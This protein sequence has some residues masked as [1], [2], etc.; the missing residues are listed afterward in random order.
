MFTSGICVFL[1]SLINFKMKYLRGSLKYAPNRGVSPTLYNK[2]Q[3]LERKINKQKPEIQSHQKA[4]FVSTASGGAHSL[5][6]SVTRELISDANFRSWITGD[7]WYNDRFKFKF[8]TD[9]TTFHGMRVVVYAPTRAATTVVGWPGGY[10]NFTYIPDPTGYMVL[11]DKIFNTP[12]TDTRFG[13]QASLSLRQLMTIYNSEADV[14][15]RNTIR[16]AFLWFDTSASTLHY[17][18]DHHFHN[19]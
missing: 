14:I 17:S 16:I 10:G 8:F 4:S 13:G 2:I 15:D 19:K 1:Y 5:D 9:D 6:L 11:Y 18:Y 7:K 3:A 12:A